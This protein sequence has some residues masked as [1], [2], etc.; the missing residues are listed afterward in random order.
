MSSVLLYELL[1]LFG[2]VVGAGGSSVAGFCQWDW[3]KIEEL[4]IMLM[5]GFPCHG[6]LVDAVSS[7]RS[8]SC[9]VKE[10]SVVGNGELAGSSSVVGA[11]ASVVALLIVVSF[12]GRY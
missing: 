8:S 3:R 10:L 7:P 11:P 1:C 12:I 6:C 4:V 9:C 2:D 5:Q